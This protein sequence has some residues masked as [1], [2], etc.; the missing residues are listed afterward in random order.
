MFLFREWIGLPG[1][2]DTY[3]NL[4]LLKFLHIFK[5]S[6]VWKNKAFLQIPGKLLS[7]SCW[8]ITSEWK[9]S[10]KC[11]NILVILQPL[12]IIILEP[13]FFSNWIISKSCDFMSNVKQFHHFITLYF[14]IILK[15][16]SC[17]VCFL[18]WWYVIKTLYKSHQ[19]SFEK[20]IKAF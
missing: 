3:C 12:W 20:Q 2:Y 8:S 5:R 11:W 6:S 10:Q 15:E 4:K 9:C 18:A 7:D 17:P 13:Q 19:I 16:N 1:I 14:H